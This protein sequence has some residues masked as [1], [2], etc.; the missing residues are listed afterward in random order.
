MQIILKSLIKPFMF[1]ALKPSNTVYF[2]KLYKHNKFLFLLVALFASAQIIN[3]IRQDVAI[4]P[5]YV[6][7]MYSAKMN[8]ENEYYVPEVFVNGIQLQTKNFSPHQWEKIIQ[9]VI[10]FNKQEV[11]NNSLY[12]NYIKRL[13]HTNKKELYVNNIS[14][15]QFTDWYKSYLSDCLHQPVN[16]CSYSFKNY[17][18]NGNFLS[19]P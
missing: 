14:Q 16:D 10:L 17:S 4:S 9:P 11:W 6:Y 12:E 18:F 15:K 19:P 7:G 3:N 1:E 5:I 13:I 8:P 2:S